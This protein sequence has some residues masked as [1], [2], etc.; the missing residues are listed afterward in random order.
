MASNDTPQ[1]KRVQ[2]SIQGM[3]IGDERKCLNQIYRLASKDD[4]A[5]IDPN[6]LLQNGQTAG[7]FSLNYVVGHYQK[8]RSKM[9][10][11]A[12]NKC[13]ITTTSIDPITESPVVAPTAQAQQSQTM[14]DETTTVESFTTMIDETTPIQCEEPATPKKP[15][16]KRAKKTI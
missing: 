14:I 13:T 8:R 4:N 10:Q 1:P 2:S 11:K 5:H 12:D 3:S 9:K 16:K 7:S 15:K 6:W